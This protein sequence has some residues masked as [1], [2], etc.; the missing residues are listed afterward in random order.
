[1]RIIDN[2]ILKMEVAR[3]LVNILMSQVNCKIHQER[4]IF[5]RFLEFEN[6]VIEVGWCSKC[7]REYCE[8]SDVSPVYISNYEWLVKEGVD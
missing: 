3:V 8:Y 6:D 7:R 4:L 1:M 2:S 5:T